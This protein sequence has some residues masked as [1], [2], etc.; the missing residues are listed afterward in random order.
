MIKFCPRCSKNLEIT[1]FKISSRTKDGFQ[2]NCEDC[3]EKVRLK[4]NERYANPEY[5]QKIL[6]K[7]REKYQN[8]PIFKEKL[9]KQRTINQLKQYHSD[10]IYKEKLN[11]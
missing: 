11:N 2:I 4:Q 10:P 8:D 3:A 7:L 9:N 5:N 6:E 1:K